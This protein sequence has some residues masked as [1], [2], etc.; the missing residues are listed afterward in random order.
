MSEKLFRI[1][2]YYGRSIA[3]RNG[4]SL[5][6]NWVHGNGTTSKTS[7]ILAGYHPPRS[8]TWR[9]AFYWVRTRR[10]F[11]LGFSARWSMYGYV[12]ILLPLIGGFDFR[13]QPYM[14]RKNAGSAPQGKE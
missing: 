3:F 10:L 8:I 1:D 11:Q 6:F 4:L 13:W 7:A 2:R 14:W 5:G 9:W 12:G